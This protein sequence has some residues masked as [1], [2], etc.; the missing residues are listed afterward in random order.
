MLSFDGHME[1]IN[2]RYSYRVSLLNNMD[3]RRWQKF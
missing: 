3:V 1:T 2:Y